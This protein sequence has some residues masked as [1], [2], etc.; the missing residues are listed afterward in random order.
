MLSKRGLARRLI[1]ATAYAGLS[2]GMVF[3]AYAQQMPAPS[4]APGPQGQP[5]AAL[6]TPSQSNEPASAV[7]NAL[8]QT[9][10]P[11]NTVQEVIVTGSS[12]RG[13]APVG[14]AVETVTRADII[15]TGATNTTELL[16]SVPEIGS[17]NSTGPNIGANQA[18][19]VDQPAIHGIGVGNG[20]G[21]LT[22][23]LLDGHRLPGAGINQTAPDP[24][25]IPTSA[26]ERV[27]VIAD[28]A[29]SIYGS[30]AVA[31]VI[32]FRLR[33]NFDGV[34]TTAKYGFDGG[35]QTDQVTQLVGKTWNTGSIMLD[36]EHS[37]NSDLA[38]RDR[39]YISDNLTSR[40]YGDFRSTNCSPANVTVGGSTFGLSAAGT[41]GPEVNH[42]EVNRDSDLYPS[43]HRDQGLISVRQKLTSNIEAYGD[44]L[45]SHREVSTLI[46]AQSS[47]E[48]NSGLGLTVP[49]T[50]P[51]YIAVPGFAGQPETVAYNPQKDT[52]G[53]HNSIVTSTFN[54]TGGLN[55][56]LGHGWDGQVEGNFGFE[57]DDVREN[58]IN[59]AVA[60]ADSANGTL[61]PYGVGA[62]TS[63]NVLNELK[64]FQVR[65]AGRQTLEE[66]LLKA[67]GPLF[68]LPG[69][70]VKAAFGF[71]VR[72][73]SF[74]AFNSNGPTQTFSDL[75]AAEQA[76]TTA[77]TVG[78]RTIESLFGEFFVPVVS[79]SNAL[80]LV[81][82]LTL[83]G[84]ARYDHYSDVGGTTNPRVGVNY[85]PVHGL[86]LR[87]SFSTSFHAPSLADAG[88][89]ID[90]RAI[91]FGDQTG[92]SNPNA[93]SVILAGGNGSLRPES[94]DNYNIGADWRP[95]FAPGLSF[96][97]SYFNIVYKDVIT[98]PTFG[99]VTEPNNPAYA[100]YAV[101]NP[102]LAEA[103]ALTAGFRHDG[104]FDVTTQLPTAIYDLRRQNFAREDI[105]GLD[106]NTQ[107][108]YPT[109]YGVFVAGLAGTYLL[110][111]TQ[112][113][114]SGGLVNN[115]LNTDYAINLKMR[116]SLSWS[117]K[118]YNATVF[119]NHTNG[120]NNPNLTPTQ[121]VDGWNTVDLHVGWNIPASGLLSGTQL[122]VD[123]NNLFNADPPFFYNSGDNTSDAR[124]YDPSAASALGRLV[125]VGVRKRW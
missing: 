105:D 43:Q 37:G 35:Y 22:L 40:G 72:H 44:V 115:L 39:P 97:V 24:S 49:A 87:A 41:P 101:L 122:T 16:R 63:P 45:Y 98:F 70:E 34:E 21:G 15:A 14:S 121:K 47:M 71:D 2:M 74:S 4:T 12:I 13:A 125:E 79:G 26:L 112:H 3:T 55:I 36:Y 84:S 23:I 28:G 1:G 124:G 64:N 57:R 110:D 20:G 107:Y 6:A 56:G 60:I 89:A 67:D 90:T 58:G 73:E 96:S 29:S 50:S 113:L 93:Y 32:N 120:Y 68:T 42:C 51:F 75:T 99:P 59:Q 17:F 103:E 82:K 114:N 100:Q 54:E 5:D 66:G 102:S 92:S 80:P 78:D 19:F 106:F 48:A 30:D 9:T 81:E 25:A 86:D 33:R 108:K 83:S 119:V 91:R 111:F 123:V 116:G 76:V 10:P 53:F 27:E 7:T 77:S 118:D 88:T 109:S 11:A 31:G 18:N 46:G 52:G 95:D 62:A 117:W 8:P 94:A 61:N 85:T 38:A 65:Y 104:T 69:G